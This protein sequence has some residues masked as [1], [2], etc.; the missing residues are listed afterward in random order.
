[1]CD[2]CDNVSSVG[3]SHKNVD[4]GDVLRGVL[5]CVRQHS[6][7]VDME[8]ATL[9]LNILCLDSMAKVSVCSHVLAINAF[10]KTHRL[11][12]FVY[13]IEYCWYQFPFLSLSDGS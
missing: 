12:V 4:V 3:F 1:M 13:S 7:R 6:V 8:Y 11:C 9:I 10:N 2:M 5:S